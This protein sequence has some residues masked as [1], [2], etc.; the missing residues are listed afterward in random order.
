MH[1]HLLEIMGDVCKSIGIVMPT[2]NYCNYWMCTPTKML[3]FIE[4]F[5]KKLKPAILTHPLAMTNASYKE[6]KLTVS[7][8]EAICGVPYYP[9]IPF[10][11]E[12]LNKAFFDKDI[13]PIANNRNKKIIIY[14]LCANEER[15]AYARNIYGDIPWAKPI[16]MKY[17]DV[18][19]ENT[20]WRQ[21]LEIKDEW[22]GCDMIGTISPSAPNKISLDRINEVIHTPSLWSS[23][24]V[25]FMDLGIPICNN[26]HP[27]LLD[28]VSDVC[29]HLKLA[30]PTENI[31]NYWMCTPAKMLRFI[32]W[33]E[34]QAKPAV[35]SHP[36]VMTDSFYNG[37]GKEYGGK[38]SSDVLMKL[39][40]VPYYP[41][42]P[43][44]IERLNKAFFDADS[45]KDK[46]TKAKT[47][48][49]ILY[50][51]HKM[52]SNVEYFLQHGIFK[53]ARYKFVIII[54]NKTLS[55]NAPDY[56][57]VINRPNIGHDF[58][59]WSQAVLSD[60]YKEY[61]NYVFINSSVV[62]PFVAEG[63]TKRWP[64]RFLE[65]LD[66]DTKIVGTTINT[67]DYVSRDPRNSSH[68]QSMTYAITRNTL[69]Y[70][71]KLGIFG[72]TMPKNK[73]ELIQNHEVRM[74]R[75]ILDS[76]FRIKCMMDYYRDIDFR[77]CKPKFNFLPNVTTDSRHLRL[78]IGH[79]TEILF[80]KTHVA[81]QKNSDWIFEWL[82]EPVK[83]IKPGVIEGA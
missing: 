29:K 4:W 48:C 36:K 71:I 59:G 37:R 24:Y 83:V 74:S 30:V 31:C 10:V 50:V 63:Y 25:H 55:I 27:Y 61:D 46:I 47:H 66:K 14:V 72:T 7:E 41:H 9:H 67:A 65:L 60:T 3:R 33:F 2:D 34:T 16:L 26:N 6:G 49:L 51:F 64:E 43:F 42:V 20:F 18:T 82:Q 77:R 13:E 28:I 19:F 75:A 69:D 22:F 73:V 40:G 35:L 12:R 21:L 52:N 11:M 70:F 54:N 8:L 76:G 58:G 23:G 1:P 78:F 15:L 68:V 57:D 17:Q 80:V 45:I 5:R 44:V 62:G 79:P 53:D 39:C 38:L 32:D 56:V 81:N